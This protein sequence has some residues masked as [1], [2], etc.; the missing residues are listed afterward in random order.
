MYNAYSQKIIN[1]TPYNISAFSI[2]C[3]HD[4]GLKCLIFMTE[5]NKILSFGLDGH[6]NEIDKG[7][8]YSIMMREGL[9]LEDTEM[10]IAHE[11]VHIK[12]ME[13]GMLKF[14]RDSIYFNNKIY[15]NISNRH[16]TDRHELQAVTIGT[17]L[18]QKNGY[19]N[20]D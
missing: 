11:L 5:S 4:L 15:P 1:N 10:I 14:N 12:Q 3:C 16:G 8:S 9:S 2:S 6:A 7:F 20:T 13:S 19:L 18:M 17:Y